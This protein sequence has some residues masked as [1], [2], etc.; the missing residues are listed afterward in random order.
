MAKIIAREVPLDTE[1]LAHWQRCIVV[2]YCHQLNA[3]TLSFLPVNQLDRRHAIVSIIR[4]RS[5][6]TYPSP[7]KVFYQLYQRVSLELERRH[8]IVSIVRVRSDSTYPSPTKVFYQLCQR[9]SLELLECHMHRYRHRG[10]RVV[11]LITKF[12][13]RQ[14]FR[15]VVNLLDGE[16]HG[17]TQEM[18]RTKVIPNAVWRSMQ[19]HSEGAPMKVNEHKKQRVR[20]KSSRKLSSELLALTIGDVL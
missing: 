19:D 8:A 11:D 14:H 5:D 16:D 4:V 15:A 12:D 2:P 20:E 6:S 1:F 17:A 18:Q 9:V 10:T 13:A 3:A 7:T